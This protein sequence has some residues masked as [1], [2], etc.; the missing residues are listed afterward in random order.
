LIS[1]YCFLN[2]LTLQVQDVL[3]WQQYFDLHQQSTLA[4]V[5]FEPA[6]PF[7]LLC[8][9]EIV[10]ATE[11]NIRIHQVNNRA[12]FNESVALNPVPVFRNEKH[13]DAE[14]ETPSWEL[15]GAAKTEDAV[16]LLLDRDPA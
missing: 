4:S 16:M 14:G 15:K 9:C 2:A 6:V 1:F 13:V 3:F 10:W 7:E 8:G 11:N 5:L 12:V